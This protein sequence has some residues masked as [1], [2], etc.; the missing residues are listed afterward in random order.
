LEI[1]GDLKELSL[2]VDGWKQ[3][4]RNLC[5][6]LKKNL[7]LMEENCVLVN[8]KF[9]WSAGRLF[10]VL[11]IF[12]SPKVSKNLLN[13]KVATEIHKTPPNL[14]RVSTKLHQSSCKPQYNTII[15]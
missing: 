12:S 11:A 7:E 8:G 1:D 9:V 4:G 14:F 2:E 3:R 15:P 5:G 6:D 13:F 10:E